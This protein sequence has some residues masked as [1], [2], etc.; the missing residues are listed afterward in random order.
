VRHRCL[1]AVA[2]AYLEHPRQR[3]SGHGLVDAGV[4]QVTVSWTP[5]TSGFALQESLNLSPVVWS[6]SPSGQTNPVTLPVT[7]ST[8]F[9]RLIKP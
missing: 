7:G 8:K 6:N 9:V 3:Q 5:P 4:S 1:Q 2:A